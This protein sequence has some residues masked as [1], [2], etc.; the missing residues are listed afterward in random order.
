[1]QVRELIGTV[2]E[3]P[4][5]TTLSEAA[6]TMVATGIGALVVRERGAMTGILSERDVLAAVG[7]G[8]DLNS[9]TAGNWMTTD[10]GSV[11]ETTDIEDAAAWLL[12]AGYRHLP[13]TDE[14]GELIGIISIKDV[15]WALRDV[16]NPIAD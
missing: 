8:K 16:T 3:C 4:P 13:V 14:D 15:L 11:V 9:E 5:S 6:Q 12:A 7:G 10:V 2:V 1:M